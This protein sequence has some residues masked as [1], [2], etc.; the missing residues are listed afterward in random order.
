M[1][2]VLVAGERRRG[3]RVGWGGGRESERYPVWSHDS[4]MRVCVCVRA[5]VRACVRE[6]VRAC[7]HV[8]PVLTFMLECMHIDM[9]QYRSWLRQRERT[10][11]FS[12]PKKFEWCIEQTARGYFETISAWSRWNIEQIYI[13]A[14]CP[15]LCGK[16]KIV[17]HWLCFGCRLC[18][19]HVLFQ[20][21]QTK[22]NDYISSPHIL[23]L[24]RTQ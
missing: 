15:V 9:S 7:V 2:V 3:V 14:F 18:S 4:S 6:C 8:S 23:T 11:T 1:C 10:N 21:A 17:N 20:K 22:H 24:K 12:W 5:C 19:K 16:T 13:G